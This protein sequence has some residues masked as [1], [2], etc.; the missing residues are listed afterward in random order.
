M[1][2]K[3]KKKFRKK[4][5][6]A[7]SGNGIEQGLYWTG[8]CVV[9][10]FA[11]VILYCHKRQMG[12]DALFPPCLF[13]RITGY[14]CPGCGAT[15]AVQALLSGNL[16]AALR[17][18]PFVVYA[19]VAGIWFLLTQTAERATGRRFRWTLRYRD[20]YLWIGL[21]VLVG[22]FLIKNLCLFVWGIDLLDR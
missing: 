21:A 16:S 22:N 2:D 3:E 6:S 19:A 20:R 9:V 14:Y 8:V 7:D 12:L 10:L 4:E 5:T 11:A 18:H 15:R 17:C 13:H 1:K